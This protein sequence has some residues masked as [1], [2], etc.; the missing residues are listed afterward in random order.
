MIEDADT[1]KES[2]GKS[3]DHPIVLGGISVFEMAC[4][5]DVLDTPFVFG[6]P[7]FSFEQWAAALHLATM[8][9]FDDLRKRIICQM[10]DLTAYASPFDVITISQKCRVEKW[11]HPAY[12]ALCRR[13]DSFTDDE[14]EWLGIKRAAALWRIRESLEFD[15]PLEI[16]PSSPCCGGRVVCGSCSNALLQQQPGAKGG[17]SRLKARV[18]K[19]LARSVTLPGSPG[20][21]LNHVLELIKMEEA[22]KF[23]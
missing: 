21:V 8:W 19:T 23:A 4:F 13:Q 22:L 1:G 17:K 6:D 10:D 9:S 11:L 3:D 20:P 15:K 16:P 5:L 14:V 2:E 7:E 18:A 12:A